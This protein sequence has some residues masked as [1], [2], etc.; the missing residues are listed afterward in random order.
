MKRELPATQH[1]VSIH[2]VPVKLF[3]VLFVW[4]GG[5]P[6][7]SPSTGVVSAQDRSAVI[8]R[9]TTGKIHLIMVADTNDFQ[10]GDSFSSDL[11][12]VPELFAENV[13]KRQLEV[14]A[15]SGN[16]VRRKK[17]LDTIGAL[18]INSDLDTV[19]FYFSGHGAFDPDRKE[20][21]FFGLGRSDFCFRSEIQ[22][23]IQQLRPQ[24]TVIIADT[25]SVY[26]RTPV[27]APAYPPAE[28]VTPAF[29]S[30]FLEPVGLIDINS[31]QPGQ[32]A[33]GNSNGGWFTST[34]CS[35]LREQQKT[36]LDW[37]T[38][39]QAVNR[40]VQGIPRA[41]QTA[42]AVSPLP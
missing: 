9:A 23:A 15:V 11:Y 10:I 1:R 36:R 37:Q 32:E 2:F 12:H 16:D 34:L 7:L 30:L 17:I 27:P 38:V 41:A 20:H 33:G 25:C 28:T 5:L 6:V 13:P 42:Y 14:T 35:Y 3:A 4:L 21:L 39:L 24:L 31:S 29:R 18:R 40:S 22:K 8:V 19:V 26:Y